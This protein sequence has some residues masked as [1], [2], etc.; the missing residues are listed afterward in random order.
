VIHSVKLVV[1]LPIIVLIVLLKD[2]VHQ[3][4]VA[5]QVLMKTMMEIV[6]IV[7]LNAVL[8][9]ILLINVQN[10]QLCM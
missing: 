3:H 8:V 1:I 9:T 7:H 6:R 10:V 5:K 4:V 2:P